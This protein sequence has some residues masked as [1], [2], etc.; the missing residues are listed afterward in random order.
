MKIYKEFEPSPENCGMKTV[1]TLGT[2]DGVHIGH[3][4]I[5]K[6]VVTRAKQIGEKA[7]VLTFDKH[8]IS[9]IRPDITP[10]LLTSLEEKL[11]IFDE[12]GIDITFV[13]AFTKKIAEMTAEQFIENYLI[14]CLGMDY[15]IVGYDHSFGRD[16]IVSSERLQKYSQKFNFNLEILQPISVEGKIV[17]SSIIRDHILEGKVDLA[18]L[19]LGENYSLSGHIVEG[20]GIGKIIGF[21]T[22]NMVPSDKGKIIPG[23]GVYSG[24]IEIENEHK[25]A[26]ITIGSRPT[27]DL[28]DELIEIH[29]PDYKGNLYGKTVRIGFFKRIRNIEKF[30]TSK[31]L[32]QQIK[33]DIEQSKQS[34]TNSQ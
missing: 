3:R 12:S 23:S 27:F 31:E 17:K 16:R 2:F 18:A 34:I 30:E 22:A 19:F 29:I 13:L 1:A 10:K 11:V 7:V 26:L 28:K 24:W 5:L 20:R 14:S 32:I 9:V 21:P 15:F 25:D 4:K 8:P 33:F 6:Q